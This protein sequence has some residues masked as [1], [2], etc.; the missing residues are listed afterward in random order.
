M[1]TSQKNQ[2]L[3]L[4]N[5]PILRGNCFYTIEVEERFPDEYDDSCLKWGICIVPLEEFMAHIERFIPIM[6]SV[7]SCLTMFYTTDFG[8]CIKIL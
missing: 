1:T 7:D 2:I 3:P 8:G 4:L 5:D 6:A